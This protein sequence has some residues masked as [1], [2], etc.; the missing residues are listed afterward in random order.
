M[1]LYSLE[2]CV[3]LK[4][5]LDF[6]VG[7]YTQRYFEGIFDSEEAAR[8][9]IPHVYQRH[10]VVYVKRD[11]EPYFQVRPYALNGVESYRQELDQED[12]IDIKTGESLGEEGYAQLDGFYEPK[13]Y[14]KSGNPIT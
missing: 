1:L 3:D 10:S 4:V 12:V 6:E 14:D 8:A 11:P 13:T 2:I 9:A 7:E 5:P